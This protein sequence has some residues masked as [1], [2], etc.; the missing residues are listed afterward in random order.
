MVQNLSQHKMVYIQVEKDGCWTNNNY[1]QS[2]KPSD[3]VTSIHFFRSVV[4]A[5]LFL[6]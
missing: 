6:L 3:M 4:I 5:F 1:Y 2:L